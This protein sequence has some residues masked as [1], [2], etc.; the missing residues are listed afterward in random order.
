MHK[1]QD[2]ALHHGRYD[3]LRRL[4]F[5]IGFTFLLLS[6]LTYSV[7]STPPGPA[8]VRAAWHSS[9]ARLLDRHGILIQQSRV[10]TTRRALDW[11]PLERISPLLVQAVIAAEDKRFYQHHGVDWAAMTSAAFDSAEGELRG[12]STLSMQLVG[13]LDPELQA[14]G[15]RNPWQKLR[16]LW[17]AERLDGRWR[18]Q[19]ILEAYLNLASFRGELVG[20]DAASRVLLGKA[21]ADLNQREAWMLA[22][23]LRAPNAIPELVARRACALAG[24][25]ADSPACETL[26]ANIGA[27]LAAPPNAVGG[28]DEAP[29]LMAQLQPAAGSTVRT[30]LDAALQMRTRALLRDQIAQLEGRNV[31]D[32]AAVILDNDTGEVRAWVGH[33]GKAAGARFVDSV[34]APRQ[35]GSTLKPFLYSLAFERKLLTPAS[36]LDDSPVALSTPGGQ[37]VPQN[38]DHHFRGPVSV[39]EALASSLNVPAVKTLMLTGLDDFHARLGTLGIALPEPAAHYGFSLALGAA[40]VRLID[41]AN[42]YRTLADGGRWS[43]WQLLPGRAEPSRQVVDPAAAWLA[44]D[45]LADRAARAP[46][47]GL[48]NVLAAPAWVAAKTGTSKDMRD[49]WCVGYTARHTVGV[50][51]GNADGEPMWDVSGVTGAAPAWRALVAQLAD[52]NMAPPHPAG[53]ELRQIRFIPA[54]EAPRREYFMA[55]TAQ[56]VIEQVGNDVAPSIVYP[57]EGLIV[58]LDPDIPAQHQLIWLHASGAAAL[59]WRMDGHPLGSAGAS[60]AWAPTPGRHLLA[61]ADAAGH[62]KAHVRFEIRGRYSR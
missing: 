59:N 6:L 47:F 22:S 12:G 40:E 14:D 52:G 2:F 34:V 48:D 61:L 56:D 21:P 45:I 16:Q 44:T 60:V 28:P 3:C 15:H 50:W 5:R 49:N 31:R 26:R 38:Y 39:R 37:Y 17:A 18:K 33:P 30:T 9:E 57:L 46:A 11:V 41:L 58:A 43:R 32:A 25:A 36:L 23:L 4:K 24:V 53:V 62:E 54:S 13:L 8:S 7:A 27:H 29:E 20:V 42:A 19:D 51:V 10:D 55:G 1:T 35:A